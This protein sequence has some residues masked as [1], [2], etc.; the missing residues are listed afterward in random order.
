VPRE[1]SIYNA[2]ISKAS[3]PNTFV[4]KDIAQVKLFKTRFKLKI[5]VA[6]SKVLVPKERSRTMHLHV[7]LSIKALTDIAQVNVFQN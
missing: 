4:S 3:K 7:Y 5:K 2:S 6:R 1:R